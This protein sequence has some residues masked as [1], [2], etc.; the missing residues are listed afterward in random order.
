[1]KGG[2]PCEAGRRVPM[3]GGCPRK[4]GVHVRLKGGFS[5]ALHSL[6]LGADGLQRCAERP[7][8]RLHR[9]RARGGRVQHPAAADVHRIPAAADAGP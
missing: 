5:C 7:D 2:C 1:M 3:E 9:L 4:A 8:L 6:L